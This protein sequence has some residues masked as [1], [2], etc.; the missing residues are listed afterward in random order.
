[1]SKSFIGA[2][3]IAVTAVLFF[4]YVMPGYDELQAD[5]QALVDR[6]KLLAD[7]E[8]AQANVQTLLKQYNSNQTSIG[9][10]LLALPKQRQYDYLTSSIQTAADAA[11]LQMTSIAMSDA[12]HTSAEYQ[13]VPIT[14]ELSGT[15][16]EFINFLKALEQSLRLFDITKIELSEGG[17]GGSSSS[18][19]IHLQL[20]AYSLK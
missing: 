15:Y 20:Q 4:M 12:Q 18:I 14:L 7:T 8:A 13:T 2:L 1:M 3:I 16:P 11:G 17:T 19:S 5:R 9:R 10:I 6:T